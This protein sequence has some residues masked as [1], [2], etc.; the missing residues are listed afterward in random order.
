MIPCRRL[1]CPEIHS[2]SEGFIYLGWIFDTTIAQYDP[3]SFSSHTSDTTSRAYE[4]M[5]SSVYNLEIG[6]SRTFVLQ[7]PVTKVRLINLH[8]TGEFL[9]YVTF[10]V[11]VHVKVEI[12]INGQFIDP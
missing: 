11:K 9:P 7:E 2:N 6:S 8:Y 1:G 5:R 3:I 10:C 4:V 12:R